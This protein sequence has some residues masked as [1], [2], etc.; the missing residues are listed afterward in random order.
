MESVATFIDGIGG[1]S[2][3]RYSLGYSL[4]QESLSKRPPLLHI[5]NG[6]CRPGRNHA[7]GNFTTSDNLC[8]ELLAPTSQAPR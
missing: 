1:G 4:T 7:S 2:A 6:A 5:P 3:G 8:A